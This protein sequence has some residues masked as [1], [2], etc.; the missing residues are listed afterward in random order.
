MLYRPDFSLQ[1]LREQEATS[2]K[3]LMLPWLR[4]LLIDCSEV[5][6]TQRVAW[7]EERLAI[8]Q[9]SSLPCAVER[10]V[11]DEVRHDNTI[12][13]LQRYLQSLPRLTTLN[14]RGCSQ[15]LI[16]DA[17]LHA[18]SKAHPQLQ[19]LY[20]PQWC[21]LLRGL[22]G[23]TRLEELD[24]TASESFTNVDSY[25]STLRVLYASSCSHLTSDGLRNATKLEVL[26][27]DA[28]PGV[29]N[30]GP[31]AHCLLE[32]NA[33]Y[34]CGINS[35]ALSAC[36]RL[37]VLIANENERIDT[38][39]P[40]AG[41]LR[42]LYTE[43]DESGMDDVALAE[44]TKLVKLS[45]S[46]NS[47]VT[48][49]SPFGRTLVDLEVTGES[50]IDDAGL[51]SATNLVCLVADS[52]PAIRSV[53][54]FASSLL[55]LDAS[56]NS[57]INDAALVHATNLVRLDCSDNH[58]ITTVA[59]FGKSLR[60]VV[61]MDGS[62]FDEDG[63]ATATNLV[64]LDCSEN[65]NIETIGFCLQSLQELTVE[66]DD[67]GL[68]WVDITRASPQLRKVRTYGNSHIT[69]KHLQRFTSIERACLFGRSVRPP[70]KLPAK[71]VRHQHSQLFLTS[72][73]TKKVACVT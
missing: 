16:S 48:T 47:F 67:C 21:T 51:Q 60:H 64:T 17:I 36:H 14:L 34:S 39:R 33:S 22:D 59:P 50:G 62:S 49:V 23:F 42:E 61:A 37:Q 15:H 73:L 63:L 45:V 58:E 52:N 11:L 66:G 65:E 5:P 35:A 13:T 7:V 70:Q 20:L 57:G 30:V 55:E 43:S 10:I 2:T 38:L 8:A 41:Q 29:T 53:A 71:K 4:L 32:L 24:V 25:A 44:A 69:A 72:K 31:F 12:V 18:M 68:D 46:F 6:P 3:C 27:V 54:P 28:C 19:R 9:R 56:A 40:F 26:H 1:Q